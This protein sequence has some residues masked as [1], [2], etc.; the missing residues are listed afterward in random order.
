MADKTFGYFLR[1]QVA[2]LS[3]GAAAIHFAEISA[4]F[5]EYRVFGTFFLAVAWFQAASSVAIATRSE[6]RLLIPI[7]VVNAIV[8]LIW[9]WSR[10]AGLPIGPEAGEPEAIGAA[11]LLA[12]VLEAL[13]VVWSLGISAPSIASRT[14]STGLGVVTTAIVWTGVVAM[15]AVV[16]LSS[17]GEVTH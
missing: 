5:Q 13:I 17:T 16:F 15:T 7:V 8:I 11:D 14:A 12:T 6:R 10:T 4:H 1:W 2:A 3:A 9:A